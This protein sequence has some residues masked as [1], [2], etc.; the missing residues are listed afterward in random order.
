MK[1]YKAT[2]CMSMP[3]FF[4]K[5]ILIGMPSIIPVGIK[6]ASVSHYA[7]W[8]IVLGAVGIACALMLF[9]LALVLL[10]NP[11]LKLITRNEAIICQNEIFYKGKR[12]NITDIKYVT[13][14][15]PA[16][17]SRRTVDPQMLA[18]WVN[19]DNSIVIKRPSLRLVADLK[20]QCSSAKFVIDADGFKSDIKFSIITGI[21]FAV[22]VAVLFF[23][24]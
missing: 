13:L 12:L 23:F 16:M 8:Q 18:L 22:I 7:F 6:L 19:D 9:A 20:K 11:L 24:F 14:Y 21:C 4:A 5:I 2:Y 17:E 3:F 15:Y 10:L 1:R